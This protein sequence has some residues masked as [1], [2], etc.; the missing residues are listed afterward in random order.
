MPPYAMSN[1]DDSEE[2]AN[3][4]RSFTNRRGTLMAS[5]YQEPDESGNRK[6]S[7][8]TV[9]GQRLNSKKRSDKRSRREHSPD[10]ASDIDTFSEV[11]NPFNFS[12]C[13]EVAAP[14]TGVKSHAKGKSANRV[15]FEAIEDSSSDGDADP[16]YDAAF[17]KM[18]SKVQK[19]QKTGHAMTKDGKYKYDLR[20]T[21]GD[22]T[23]SLFGSAIDDSDSFMEKVTGRYTKRHQKSPPV[24]EATGENS[25]GTREPVVVRVPKSKIFTVPRLGFMIPTRSG[26]LHMING[27]RPAVVC[28]GAAARVNRPDPAKIAHPATPTAL[29]SSPSVGV[30]N[31]SNYQAPTVESVSDSGDLAGL[32][33]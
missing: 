8:K 28:R 3:L 20:R 5:N 15:T 6:K 11:G 7:S 22:D 16:G 27:D 29:Q 33:G 30:A 10:L 21:Y 2:F 14:V 18:M 17:N 32:F 23:Q 25:I 26:D 24:Q 9:D 12:T 19:A 1:I 13:A 4:A 31:V